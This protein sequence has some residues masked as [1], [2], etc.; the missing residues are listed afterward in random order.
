[1]DIGSIS[2]NYDSLIKDSSSTNK[3]QGKLNTT[4]FTGATDEQMMDACKEFES[5]FL[6]MVFKEMEK[7]AY[8]FSDE[9]QGSNSQLVDYFKETT[10]QKLTSDSTETQ[11]LG[12]AQQLFEQMKRNY[13]M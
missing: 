12:L 7:T 5:Y 4:D 13:G 11:G 1:M 3:L 10:M 9:K 2:S 8:V 6:E